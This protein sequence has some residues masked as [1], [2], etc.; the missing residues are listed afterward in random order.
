MVLDLK[1]VIQ[2]LEKLQMYAMPSGINA[3][4]R[5]FKE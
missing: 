2:K 4:S 3:A 5:Y 1:L